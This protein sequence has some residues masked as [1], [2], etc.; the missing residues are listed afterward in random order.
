LIDWALT[1]ALRDR[2][3]IGTQ[4]AAF[5]GDVGLLIVVTAISMRTT[6]YW[7]LVAAAF[8]LLCVTVH[9]ARTVDPG[10]HAWAYATAQVIFTQMF[11]VTIG[12]GVWNTWREGRQPAMA[13]DEPITE[14]A[15]TRR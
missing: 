9:I 11:V 15:A 4:W 12:V 13:D 6:R 14:P 3:W 1:I 8:E 7:P 2:S 10:V 5:A